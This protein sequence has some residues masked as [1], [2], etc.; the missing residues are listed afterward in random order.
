MAVFA[1]HGYERVKPPLLEFEDSLLAGSGAA[2]ADQTFRL[3][4]PD[5]HRMMGRARRT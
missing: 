4:D 3:M 2:V 1:S 5:T